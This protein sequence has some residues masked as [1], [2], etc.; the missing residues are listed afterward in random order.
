MQSRFSFFGYF[1]IEDQLMIYSSM[2]SQFW[3]TWDFIGVSGAFLKIFKASHYGFAMLSHDLILSHTCYSY[4]S[5]T[6]YGF[7][8]VKKMKDERSRIYEQTTPKALWGALHETPNR[9]LRFA[10]NWRFIMISYN[11]FLFSYR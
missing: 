9:I 1:L 8:T 7:A 2:Q 5:E 11:T 10:Y 6:S 3:L 4:V